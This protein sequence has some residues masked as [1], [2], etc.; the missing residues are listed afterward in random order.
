MTSPESYVVAAADAISAARPGARNDSLERYIE[1]LTSLEE[2]ALRFEGVEKCFAIQAGREV[3]VMVNPEEID[4]VKASTL[5]RDISNEI[6][7][8]LNFPGQIKVIVIRETRSI[9]MTGDFN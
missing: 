8:E 4:D 9:Q 2:I 7:Q 5:A 6:K 3:R 1:R